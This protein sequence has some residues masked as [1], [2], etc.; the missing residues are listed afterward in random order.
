MLSTLP[1]A[2]TLARQIGFYRDHLKDAPAPLDA[3]PAFGK[4]DIARWVYVADTDAEARRDTADGIVR[5]ISHFMSGA[6]AGYLGHVS[7]KSRVD[8]LN[9]DDLLATTLLHGSPET[10]IA[11]LRALRDRTGLTSL[12]LHY[13][14]YYGHEKTMRSLRLLAERVMPEVGVS[15]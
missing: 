7:E 3:N 10:V 4:V 11:K 13:P 1:S 12:L 15:R 5:H 8:T 9:Y 14:P 6:T 2:E